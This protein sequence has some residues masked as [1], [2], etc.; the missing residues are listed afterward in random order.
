MSWK[1]Q[2]FDSDLLDYSALSVDER[3]SALAQLQGILGP[4]G[5]ILQQG[6]HRGAVFGWPSLA[7]LAWRHNEKGCVFRG[8]TQVWPLQ[9]AIGRPGARKTREG[10]DRP[11]N[12]LGEFAALKAFE[13]R[14]RPYLTQQPDD[15]LYEWLAVARH[16][17]LP[18]RLLDWTESFLVAAMFACNNSGITDGARTTPEICTISGLGVVTSLSGG[19]FEIESVLLYGPPHITPRIPAQQGVFTVHPQPEV[20]LDN[21]PNLERWLIWSEACFNIKKQLDVCGINE[22]TLFPDMD[23]LGRYLGWCYKWDVPIG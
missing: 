7:Q 11:H 10:N 17:G 16:H 1:F 9:P 13:R 5:T 6:Q 19:P 22:S 15:R 23:G 4:V 8:Q 3:Q 2:A 18:T 12:Q 14:C 21:H 20:P